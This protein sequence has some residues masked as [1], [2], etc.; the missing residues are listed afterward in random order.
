MGH[1]ENGEV[2]PDAYKLSI[3]FKSCIANNMNTSVFQYYVKMTGY[4]SGPMD[5]ATSAGNP[6]VLDNNNVIDMSAPLVKKAFDAAKNGLSA[7]TGGGSG[8]TDETTPESAMS[9]RGIETMRMGDIL[10]SKDFEEFTERF[11]EATYN[12]KLGK[13]RADIGD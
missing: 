10:D 9:K 2:L 3:K 1:R 5:S 13:L 8:E 6:G 11:N 12:K 4:D 7:I